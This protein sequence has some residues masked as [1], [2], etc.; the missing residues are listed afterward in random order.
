MTDRLDS[1]TRSVIDQRQRILARLE[2][3][4]GWGRIGMAFGSAIGGSRHAWEREVHVRPWG[5]LND[6]ERQLDRWEADHAR[7]A[8]L[9]QQFEAED[10]QRAEQ[11]ANVEA[12]LAERLARARRR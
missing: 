11:D 1:F 5:I 3:I 7:H 4:D 9:R 8:I 6:I 12:A 2:K 10:Q